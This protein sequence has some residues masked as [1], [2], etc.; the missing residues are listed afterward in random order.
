MVIT[1]VNFTRSLTGNCRSFSNFR[2]NLLAEDSVWTS[3]DRLCLNDIYRS[4]SEKTRAETRSSKCSDVTV[5][6]SNNPIRGTHTHARN[7]RR[8]LIDLRETY[9][10]WCRGVN[11]FASRVRSYRDHRLCTYNDYAHM[12]WERFIYI[13]VFYVYPLKS[14]DSFRTFGKSK[15]V[16]DISFSSLSVIMIIYL[17]ILRRKTFYECVETRGLTIDCDVTTDIFLFY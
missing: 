9:T 7:Q 4:D 2:L 5:R 6:Q 12:H 11:I 14:V 8:G 16:F 13:H 17:L 15:K 1:L 10:R 3:P